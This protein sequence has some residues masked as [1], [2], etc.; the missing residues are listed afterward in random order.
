MFPHRDI[1]LSCCHATTTAP[2]EQRHSAEDDAWIVVN[3]EAI[4]VTKWIAIH[5]GGEQAIMAY[6]GKDLWGS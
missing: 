4:D 1:P 3:G 5:P 2:S 6:L